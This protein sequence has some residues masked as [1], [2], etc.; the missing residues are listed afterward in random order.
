MRRR[1]YTCVA[2][3]AAALTGLLAG[4]LIAVDGGAAV[5]QGTVTTQGYTIGNGSV[6]GATASA[7]PDTAGA[8]ADYTVGLTTPSALTKGSSTVTLS[9]PNGRTTFPAPSTDYF[10]VDNSSPRAA[11]PWR[12]PTWGPAATA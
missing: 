12:A 9:A 7:Q 3:G 2:L 5:A 4:P 8:T 6:S 10:V 1:T 11:S